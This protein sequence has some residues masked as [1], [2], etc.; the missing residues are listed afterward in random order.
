M[1]V[2]NN[3]YNAASLSH[4]IIIWKGQTTKGEKF[5]EKKKLFL[6]RILLNHLIK[7][8]DLVKETI[9]LNNKN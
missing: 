6:Q 5:N 2:S 7:S 8:E 3:N 9:I 1:K 4:F